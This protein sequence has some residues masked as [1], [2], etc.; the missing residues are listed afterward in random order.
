MGTKIKRFGRGSNLRIKNKKI[1]LLYPEARTAR[2]P[3]GV[4]IARLAIKIGDK[5]IVPKA[6]IR[7]KLMKETITNCPAGSRKSLTIDV[8]LGNVII[9]NETCNNGVD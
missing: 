7:A 1:R 8:T 5:G 4:M 2:Q 6:C 3:L 9:I